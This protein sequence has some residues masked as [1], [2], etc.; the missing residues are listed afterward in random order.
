MRVFQFLK[1]IISPNCISKI[2]RTILI[3]LL[4]SGINYLFRLKNRKKLL[5]L[6]YHG[7]NNTPYKFTNPYQI[8]KNTFIKHLNYL[9]RKK[10]H[11]INLDDWLKIVKRGLASKNNF[12][13]LTFD[14]GFKSIINNVY[15]LMEEY[16]IKGHFY[17]VSDFISSK[18]L[19][20]GNFL[21][22]F[23]G[24]YKKTEF[25][26]WYRNQNIKYLLKTE[27]EKRRALVDIR[28]KLRSLN[29]LELEKHMEQFK[30]K[31]LPD[32]LSKLYKLFAYSTWSEI[33]FLDKKVLK[34]GCHT[35]THPFLNKITNEKEIYLELFNSKKKIKEEIGYPINHLSYPNGLYSKIIIQYA[36]KYEYLT[37][38]TTNPGLNSIK[39]NLFELKRIIGYDDMTY[40]KV[41]VSGLYEFIKNFIHNFKIPFLRIVNLLKEKNLN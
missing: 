39:T 24:N 20:K 34:L 3:I 14:D 19:L 6:L 22:T 11:F 25:I 37:A 21:D 38:V 23:I 8:S 4:K 29:K 28:S 36:K 15:P 13:I 12:V 33:K 31:K 17:V 26:F 7:I 40:F 9:N 2:K 41:N 10:Y 27:K 5:I 30:E 1:N 18:Q 32:E 35:K 16:G